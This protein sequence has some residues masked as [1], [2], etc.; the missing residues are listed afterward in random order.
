MREALKQLHWRVILAVSSIVILLDQASK[1]L[2]EQ[3]FL[4]GEELPIIEGLF[5]L[6]LTYNKG[7]AFG[8]FAQFST[9]PRTVFL[10]LAIGLAL[11]VIGLLLV[12]EYR[13][14]PWGQAFLAM[15]LGGAIG[16]IIDR[17]RIGAVVDFIDFYYRTYHWPAF[18]LADSAICVGV[19]LLLLRPP[20]A[21]LPDQ[22]A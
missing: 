21:K 7:V 8:M 4:E 3:L 5:N 20:R 15:I 12:R 14:D 11:A 19:F 17:L 2:I 6:T 18:N 16:N 13:H 22:V 1:L 9:L 10:V